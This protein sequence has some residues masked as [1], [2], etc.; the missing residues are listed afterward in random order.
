MLSQRPV[1][2]KHSTAAR[3]RL[4]EQQQEG[5]DPGT[6]ITVRACGAD[7]LRDAVS[8]L[9][10]QCGGGDVEGHI[11]ELEKELFRMRIPLMELVV[12]SRGTLVVGAA[13]VAHRY[14]CWSG[15]R[16]F[17][18]GLVVAEGFRRQGIGTRL[19]E[20]L[21]QG[22]MKFSAEAMEWQ[23][24]PDNEGAIRFSERMGA[25]AEPIEQWHDCEWPT[26]G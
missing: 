22:A 24:A 8:L 26:A 21:A 5:A 13:M 16:A 23:L 19:M 7:E 3:E 14:S 6:D 10:E 2:R 20:T 12:A 25:L 1:F 4:A 15:R 11:E 9:R 17:L 18:C